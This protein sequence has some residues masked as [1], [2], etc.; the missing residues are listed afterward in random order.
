M[1]VSLPNKKLAPAIFSGS[2]FLSP[3]LPDFEVLG[4]PVTFFISWV[5]DKLEFF[6]LRLPLV[7]QVSRDF[8]AIVGSMFWPS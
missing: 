2:Q 8:V 5:A 4:K 6:P 7:L 3:Y 1:E